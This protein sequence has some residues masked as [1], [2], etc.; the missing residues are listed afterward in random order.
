M[1]VPIRGV[2]KVPCTLAKTDG[3]T[4]S[5]AID[6]L[7]REAGRSVVC[8]SATVDMITAKIIRYPSQL[9]PTCSEK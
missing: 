2:W 3:Y 8:V 6:K 5:R 9:P 1:T 7:S 4:S